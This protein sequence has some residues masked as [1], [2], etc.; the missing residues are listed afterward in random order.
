[1]KVQNKEELNANWRREH[2]NENS[3][4]HSVGKIVT[5]YTC[6]CTKG[7]EPKGNNYCNMCD[8]YF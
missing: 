2:L 6:N 7:K 8:H 5:C 4:L 3:V 1:M